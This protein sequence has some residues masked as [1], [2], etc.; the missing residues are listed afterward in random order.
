MSLSLSPA[1]PLTVTFSIQPHITHLFLSYQL[2]LSLSLCP[3]QQPVQSIPHVSL[4]QPTQA[5]P[6][7]LSLKP[8]EEMKPF[9]W[10]SVL[11]VDPGLP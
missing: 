6:S 10:S 2:L 3:H 4:E 5:C 8:S 1:L 11:S 7:F 9:A